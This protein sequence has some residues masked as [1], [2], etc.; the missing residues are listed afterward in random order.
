MNVAAVA[1]GSIHFGTLDVEAR[2]GSVGIEVRSVVESLAPR[3]INVAAQ[4]K[5]EGQ[6]IRD[7][8]IILT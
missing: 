8:E 6:S 4:P 3:L 5:V 1:I 2:V 7:L